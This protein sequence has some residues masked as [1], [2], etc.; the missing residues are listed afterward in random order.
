MNFGVVPKCSPGGA[1]VD[2]CPKCLYGWQDFMDI[3]ES[4]GLES[5][6]LL[7]CYRCGSIFIS[8]DVRNA[9]MDGKKEY[10]LSL[11]KPGEFI[12]KCGKACRSKTGLISHERHCKECNE[13]S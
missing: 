5:G 4:L 13:R 6:V 12:A 9:D 7:G 2:K 1:S 10:L 3:G 11:T 8:K